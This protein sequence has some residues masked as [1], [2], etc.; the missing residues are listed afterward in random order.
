MQITLKRN[1][2]K[3]MS[4]VA[5]FS[6]ESWGCSGVGPKGEVNSL[7]R[8]Q[9]DGWTDTE[10]SARAS[11]FRSDRRGSGDVRGTWFS[12]VSPSLHLGGPCLGVMSVRPP[13]G[14]QMVRLES[15]GVH[16]PS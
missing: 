8:E 10:D 12:Q 11:L 16:V 3:V 2:F 5:S 6:P 4:V 1:G 9:T 14:I 13:G 15:A 7:K